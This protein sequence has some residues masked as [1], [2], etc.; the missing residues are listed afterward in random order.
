MLSQ[1]NVSP[2]LYASDTPPQTTRAAGAGLQLDA[3]TLSPGENGAWLLRFSSGDA[4]AS[5]QLRPRPPA[6]ASPFSAGGEA[7]GWTVTA[8][9]PD[10]DLAGQTTAARRGGL[11]LG[12]AVLLHRAGTQLRA[13]P[14]ITVL[15]ATETGMIGLHQEAGLTLAWADGAAL[16]SP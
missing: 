7:D 4:S 10:A 5:L 12:R 9:L 16:R 1:P 3:D 6:P 14:R 2:I 11:T 8:L 15:V 13:G